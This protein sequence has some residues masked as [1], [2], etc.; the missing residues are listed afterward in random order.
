MSDSVGSGRHGDLRTRLT[1]M[2]Q[3]QM[4]DYLLQKS[5]FRNDK[6]IVH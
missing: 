4:I 6:K 5:H 3:N 2:N 1:G